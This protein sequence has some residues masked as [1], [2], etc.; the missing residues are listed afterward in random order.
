MTIWVAHASRVLVLVSRRNNLLLCGILPAN[1][2]LR[3]VRDREDAL[4]RSP[5]DESVR[6]ADMRD[7]RA[8]QNSRETVIGT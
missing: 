1:G 4:A 5:R 2:V 8:T 7:G 6:L 3:K